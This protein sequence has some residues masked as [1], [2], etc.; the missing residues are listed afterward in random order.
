MPQYMLLI[1]GDPADA[2]GPD[3]QQAAME[4]WTSYTQA[5]QESGAMKAGDALEPAETATTVRVRDGET[6]VSDGP[7]ADTK[8]IL[9]GYYLLDL[10]DLDAALEWAA[11]MPNIT[12]GSVEVRPVMVFE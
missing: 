10:P 1:Y 2:P 7:F 11:K 6:I 8:E 4:G 5:L 3:E 12:Y 9:G